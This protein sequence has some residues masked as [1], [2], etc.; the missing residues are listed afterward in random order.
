MNEFGFS[1]SRHLNFSIVLFLQKR[2]IQFEEHVVSC[3][4]AMCER[5]FCNYLLR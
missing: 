2:K 3:S 4:Y 1:S 5:Q